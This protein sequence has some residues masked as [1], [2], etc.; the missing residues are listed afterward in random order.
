MNDLRPTTEIVKAILKQDER[1]RNSDSYLY[2]KVIEHI[3]KQKGIDTRKISVHDFWLDWAGV[4]PA[5]ETVRRTR[6]KIQRACPELA[7][8]DR[9]KAFQSENEKAVR[10]YAKGAI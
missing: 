9:V 6:Q 8:C 2:H 3:A 4:F 10:A 1:A 7:A 5:A